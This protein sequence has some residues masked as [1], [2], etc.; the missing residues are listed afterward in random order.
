MS[1]ACTRF[2]KITND[3]IIAMGWD[4]VEIGLRHNLP[5]D[6]LHATAKEVAKRMNKNIR[7]VYRNEYEYDKE[8]NVVREAK[9]DEFIELGKYEVNN[10]NLN[11]S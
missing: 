5:V 2:Y 4:V 8:K 10:S 11:N 7:L 3:K 9:G 1:T 6:D